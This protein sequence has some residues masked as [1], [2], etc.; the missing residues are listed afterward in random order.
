MCVI[1]SVSERVGAP[2]RRL[3]YFDHLN[4][5][6][7]KMFH[8]LIQVAA[9]EQL[10][11]TGQLPKCSRSGFRFQPRRCSWLGLSII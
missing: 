1:W 3:E 2:R 9:I 5:A 4:L 10:A 7:V 6:A 11:H 8:H